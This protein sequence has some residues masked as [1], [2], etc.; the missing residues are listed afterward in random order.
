MP[1]YL[2]AGIV[3][4]MSACTT[5]PN[6]PGQPNPTP[7]ASAPVEV[8]NY[9]GTFR[10]TFLCDEPQ[11]EAGMQLIL[12]AGRG[13]HEVRGTVE[14]Y[15]TEDNPNLPAGSFAVVGQQQPNGLLFVEPVEWLKRPDRSWEMIR[16]TYRPV[17]AQ[18]SLVGT[19][20]HEKCDWVR[21]QR[22]N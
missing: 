6:F 14:F 22:V 16:V 11:G 20:Q 1:K 3:I 19:L 8:S 12:S 15:P 4:C 18:G 9:Y 17:T 10:G 7:A 21:L 5:A 2:I 13:E